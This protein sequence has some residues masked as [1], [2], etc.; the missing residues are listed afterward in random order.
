MTGLNFDFVNSVE[1][2]LYI[3][4][5]FVSVVGLLYVILWYRSGLSDNN[6]I[7]TRNICENIHRANLA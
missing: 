1:K 6:N 4:K 2:I 3:M 7:T 5:E